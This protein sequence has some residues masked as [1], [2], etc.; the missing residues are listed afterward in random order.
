[1]AVCLALTAVV[2]MAAFAIAWQG[3]RAVADFDGSGGE[4]AEIVPLIATRRAVQP[5]RTTTVL[6][7][8]LVKTV[9]EAAWPASV[10]RWSD[11]IAEAATAYQIDA[12]LI[13]AIVLNESRGDP[14]AVSEAGA[15]GL[16][17]VMPL[18]IAP[19][20]LYDP[21]TNLE[22]GS[23]ILARYLG[24]TDGDLYVALTI[25]NG[26]WGNRQAAV[27]LAYA[28]QVQHDYGSAV[29]LRTG[30]ELSSASGLWTIGV[31]TWLGSPPSRTGIIS[32]HVNWQGPTFG[33]HVVYRGTRADGVALTVI[34]Y[35]MPVSAE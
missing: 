4:S 16:M 34:G 30:G 20:P 33:E 32:Q 22:N 15:I 28:A 31:R 14:S 18:E 12:D 9:T 25:Y 21:T 35:V 17:G 8:T 13:A 5:V 10:N 11:A 19:A 26:G 6:P 29:A 7:A 23:N 3:G 2:V 24:Q 27:P 1:M